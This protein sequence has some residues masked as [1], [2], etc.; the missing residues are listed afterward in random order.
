M[1]FEGMR[2]K[3]NDKESYFL[4]ANEIYKL[5]TGKNSDLLVE[6]KGNCNCVDNI[7]TEE[8]I[9]WLEDTVENLIKLRSNT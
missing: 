7:P 4:S 8:Y 5:E 6:A 2:M 3:P 9:N 1:S